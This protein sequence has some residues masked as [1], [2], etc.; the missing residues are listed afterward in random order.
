MLALDGAGKPAAVLDLVRPPTIVGNQDRSAS[1]PRPHA[2]LPLNENE[3]IVTDAGR[4]QVLL[5]R[6]DMER[7][8]PSLEL[9]QGLALQTGTGPRHL[10][11]A[12]REGLF[13]VSNQNSSGISIIERVAGDEGPRLVLRGVLSD[14]GLGRAVA[15]PSEIAV[16]SAGRVCYLANRMDESLSIFSI[17]A[18]SGD[19]QPLG[20]IDVMGKN[21]RHFAI[22]PGGEWLLVAN[23]DSGDLTVFHIEDDGRRV[24]RTGGRIA[25]SSPTVVAF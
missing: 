14:P 5:Y 25:V 12:P 22:A 6:L 15:V 21:P 23:Q 13:Y 3:L 2:V 24:V 10:A 20:A 9:L 1:P 7:A 8:R 17:E 11:R 18:G 19:L 16:H 4:D